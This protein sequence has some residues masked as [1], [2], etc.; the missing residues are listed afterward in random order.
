MLDP[1]CLLRRQ[2]Q[3]CTA[4]EGPTLLSD[5][6]SCL[7]LE[8]YSERYFSSVA[9]WDDQNDR[10]DRGFCPRRPYMMLWSRQYV[11]VFDVDSVFGRCC[12]TFSQ[13]AHIAFTSCVSRYNIRK[14][15]EYIMYE[16]C[17][18]LL[19]IMYYTLLDGLVV[20]K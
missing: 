13:G 3:A 11:A 6:C 17:I 16:V 20:Q 19:A 9:G 8:R 18:H 5:N 15:F 7:R 10:V 1:A 12:D 14:H 2:M 4:A